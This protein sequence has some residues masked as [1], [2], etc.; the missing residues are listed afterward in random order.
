MKTLVE[1]ILQS[2]E[3]QIVSESIFDDD[4]ASS[5][6]VSLYDLFGKHI[7]KFQHTWGGGL[8]WTHFYNQGAVVREWKKEGRPELSGGFAKT[9]FP[10]DLQ[11]F[12]AV[13]L[14]NTIVFKDELFKLSDGIIDD[15]F[16]N[17]R[18]KKA[19]II[20][21]KDTMWGATDVGSRRIR[22][23]ISYIEGIPAGP[24][25]GVGHK[26]VGVKRFKGFNTDKIEISIYAYD[27]KWPG[28]GSHI[29]T[30]LTD[31][32]INDLKK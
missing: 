6:P 31:L 23:Q 27:Q 3:P 22:V 9:T 2:K 5:K 28:F 17:T 11:K 15:E 26:N 8:G 30:L 13:I 12:I 29:W 4:L 25:H 1:S 19:D 10:S 32:T 20:W 21:P 24:D 16:L 14:N 7:K 18:L